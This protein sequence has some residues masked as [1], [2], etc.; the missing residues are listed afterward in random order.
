MAAAGGKAVEW[1]FSNSDVAKA[2]RKAFRDEGLDIKV[3]YEKQ[4]PVGGT[5]KPGAFG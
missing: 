2:A 5:R 1:H 4:K 3:V